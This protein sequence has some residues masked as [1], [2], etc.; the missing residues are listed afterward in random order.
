[1][2]Y[3]LNRYLVIEPFEER[4]TNTGVLV[5]EDYAVA[6]AFKLAEIIQAHEASKLEKGMR[7]VVPSHMVEEVAFSGETYYLVTENNVVGIHT[8][9]EL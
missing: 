1:M 9:K 6:S 7:I 5:P 2:L 4:K 8:E 3:P